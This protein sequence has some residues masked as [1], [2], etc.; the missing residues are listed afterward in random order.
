MEEH[1]L[2][3]MITDFSNAADIYGQL[4]SLQQENYQVL[5]QL[6]K[7]YL[8]PSNIKKCADLGIGDGSG[9]GLHCLPELRGKQW[10]G[11]DLSEG[12]LRV[13]RIRNQECSPDLLMPLLKPLVANAEAL[14]LFSCLDL[15]ISNFTLHWV[16][17]LERAFSEIIA[18]IKPE[19]AFALSF[20]VAG[21]LHELEH[22]WAS[23]GM[24]AVH[25]FP[26]LEYVKS[27]LS[28][29]QIEVLHFSKRLIEIQFKSGLELLKWLKLTGARSKS[30]K[31]PDLTSGKLRKALQF[32]E[33]GEDKKA[34][35]TF[36]MIDVVAIKHL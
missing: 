20:P 29:D 1:Y 28:K 35:I 17:N 31:N 22:A 4:A 8:K 24:K 13:L 12:M 32:L 19:G 6:V 14:P 30:Q 11:V 18:A 2:K 21:S 33:R 16:P 5:F 9:I 25:E 34:K 27:I 10:F 23:I 36:Y 3:N 7:E 15:I 26:N